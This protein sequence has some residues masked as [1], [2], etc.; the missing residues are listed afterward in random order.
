MRQAFQQKRRILISKSYKFWIRLSPHSAQ[1][2]PGGCHSP[3][4]ARARC[5]HASTAANRP[6]PPWLGRVPPHAVSATWWKSPSWCL[7][8]IVLPN[9]VTMTNY[10][11][12]APLY[13]DYDKLQPESFHHVISP[14]ALRNAYTTDNQHGLL[15]QHHSPFWINLVSL[16]YRNT[17]TDSRTNSPD[18]TDQ[19]LNS[20][21][22]AHA[23][24]RK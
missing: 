4:C 5:G 3:G 13:H 1:D 15:S 11:M 12:I 24:E 17:Y 9:P 14:T 8:Y 22:P 2:Q 19:S 20:L 23:C 21:M 6:C 7:T 10:N 18:S 16:G